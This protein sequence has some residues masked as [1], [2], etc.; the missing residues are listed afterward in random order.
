MR[1][2]DVLKRT[3]TDRN[4]IIREKRYSLGDV[5]VVDVVFAK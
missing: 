3:L 1:R 2:L 5:M 4:E